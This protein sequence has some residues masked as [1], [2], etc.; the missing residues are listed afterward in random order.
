MIGG[1]RSLLFQWV[2][3]SAVCCRAGLPLCFLIV[4][5][6]A[7]DSASASFDSVI[8]VDVI[9]VKSYMDSF[10]D[11]SGVPVWVSI[12]NL[13]FTV[14]IWKSYMWTAFEEQI[15]KRS[16]Q[17]RTLNKSDW[18]SSENKAWKRFRLVRDLSPWL[19]RWNGKTY[20]REDERT[21]KGI[22]SAR[23]YATTRFGTK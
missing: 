13:Y 5:I 23:T 10:L 16:S 12:N 17:L 14:N 21:R 6:H 3:P 18:G 4:G 7:A 2:V 22:R 19:L 11:Y 15:W 8:P 9:R 1:F 20:A